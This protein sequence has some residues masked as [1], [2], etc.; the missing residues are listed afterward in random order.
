[1]PLAPQS[2]AFS[3]NSPVIA[4]LQARWEA[5]SIIERAESVRRLL[6][7]TPLSR[8]AL[9]RQLNIDEGSVRRCLAIAALT[10]SE[11]QEIVAGTS[12]NAVLRRAKELRGRAERQRREIEESDTATHSRRLAADIAAWIAELPL[13]PDDKDRILSAARQHLWHLR[14]K[15]AR[16]QRS[17]LPLAQIIAQSEPAERADVF[18]VER[19]I[20]WLVSWLLRRC[21][22]YAILEH[23]LEIAAKSYAS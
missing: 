22:E 14:S 17:G 16:M 4:D 3:R 12:A 8:R 10:E 1:M 20:E 15:L 23:A 7:E 5:T 18:W 13:W 19:Y 9:A 2:H 6:Q 11:K 21:P